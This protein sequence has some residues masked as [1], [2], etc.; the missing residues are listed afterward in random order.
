MLRSNYRVNRTT[1]FR[2]LSEDQMEDI[3]LAVLEVLGKDRDQGP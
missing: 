2:V 1:Q 3:H